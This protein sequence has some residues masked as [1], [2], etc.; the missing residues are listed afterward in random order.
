MNGKAEEE[1]QRRRA[2][3]ASSF[4]D[5]TPKKGGGGGRE[6]IRNIVTMTK[7]M[8][9]L[10]AGRVRLLVASLASGPKSFV[11]SGLHLDWEFWK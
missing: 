1:S 10:K 6:E 2:P 5:H 7:K 11:C 9:D 3:V 4:G 8:L